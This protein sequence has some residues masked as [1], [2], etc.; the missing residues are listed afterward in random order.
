MDEQIRVQNNEVTREALSNVHGDWY[1]WLL[2][3]T[4]WNNFVT[5]PSSKLAISLPNVSQF[6][7]A[8]LYTEELSNLIEDL[9]QKVLDASSVQLITSNPDYVIIDGTLARE[10]ITDLSEIS[11][12]DVGSLSFLDNLYRQFIGR[13]SFNQIVGYIS[14]KT[15]LRPDRRLQLA[16]EGSLMKAIYT[17]LQTRQWIINPPGL[18]YYGMSTRVGASDREALKTVATHS[19]TT[20]YSLPQAAVDEVYQVNSVQEAQEAFGQ[21][22]N[23][24]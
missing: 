9:K 5:Q 6:V 13:C 17:H 24:L 4:A 21:I 1:E 14:V 16:H 18:K 15:S 3:I 11:I 20:V 12:V 22:L 19:I 23:A 10:V 7:V 2:S 8:K